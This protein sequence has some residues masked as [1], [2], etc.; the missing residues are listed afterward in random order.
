MSKLSILT[1]EEF[2][3]ILNNST[4]VAD[5]L[6]KV[7]YNSSPGW[8]YP[9]IYQ[10]I[11]E[12]NFD[13]NIW[14]QNNINIKRFLDPK[15]I[16]IKGQYHKGPYLRDNLI[17]YQLKEYK[18]EICGNTG[19][20][21]GK[22]ITLQVDHINGDNTDNRLENLRFLCPNC[23]SQTPTFCSRKGENFIPFKAEQIKI[24]PLPTPEDNFP[25]NQ[26]KVNQ[27]DLNG[28]YIKTYNS[29]IEGCKDVSNN[30]Y[31][32]VH[33]EESCKNFNKTYYNYMWRYTD[34]FPPNQDINPYIKITKNSKKVSQYDVETGTLIKTY[35]SSK[36]AEII[37][38]IDAKMIRRCAA[39]HRK[40][41]GGYIWKYEDNNN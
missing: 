9:Y 37:T 27:Y 2:L 7:G 25:K 26:R 30:Q 31:G 24:R 28:H 29:L 1:D 4:S 17:R 19:E 15:D 5:V 34:E 40:T 35:L 20:W 8:A 39:G 33:I 12:L 32:Y 18:C 13:T 6:R 14:N 16:F 22:P 38:G 11:K 21:N 3:N 36:E 10:K 23:H 41:C